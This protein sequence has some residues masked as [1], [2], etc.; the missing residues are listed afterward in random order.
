[1]NNESY[2]TVEQISGMMQLHPKTIQR[3]IREGRLKA[4]K[5]GKSWRVTGHDLSVFAEGSEERKSEASYP[6]L[7]SIVGNSNRNIK[8]SSVIDFP[9]HNSGESVRI[10]NWISATIQSCP[11]EYGY[12][13]MTSQYI[14]PDK[15]VRIML[16]GS[17]A[18]TAVIL[19]ALGSMEAE[20][21][22]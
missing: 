7:Q 14:E 18:F 2:Y 16:W 21:M 8:V 5:V 1:M 12:K 3:H 17:P 22:E 4:Q 15:I 13:S 10:V 19:D 9:V 11:P 20:V 6:G